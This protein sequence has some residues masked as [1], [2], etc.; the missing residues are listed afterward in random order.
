[1]DSDPKKQTREAE[2][3]RKLAFF[4]VCVSTVATLTA[5]VA[6]PM[7]YNYMQSVQSTLQEEVDFCHHRSSGLWEEYA[8]LKPVI[9]GRLKRSDYRRAYGS[10][11]YNGYG[12]VDVGVAND[13]VV[14]AGQGSTRRSARKRREA[15]TAAS[16]AV[17]TEDDFCFD[18]PP[19]PAG[20]AGAPGPKGPNGNVGPQ[21]QD[22]AP[23]AP[24]QPGQQG[25]AGPKGNAGSPGNAGTAGAPGK[26][27]EKPGTDGPPGPAGPQGA[28]GLDGHP[29][30]DGKPGPVGQ[31]GPQGDAGKDGAPGQNGENGSQGPDGPEGAQGGCDHCPIPRTAPG[32]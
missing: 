12:A 21:G 29:G 20:P 27:I 22:G 6:V 16:N 32:Y 3:L 2:S 23:G 25:P 13:A 5:I 8:R 14:A 19:G 24:G 9:G 17:P 1:M 18:C 10:T 30:I 15:R 7:V 28:P 31:P 26:V 11:S 4:G